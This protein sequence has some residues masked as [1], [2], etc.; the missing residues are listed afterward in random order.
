MARPAKDRVSCG[1]RQASLHVGSRSVKAG[2]LR[3][4]RFRAS[5]TSQAARRSAKARVSVGP[6]ASNSREPYLVLTPSPT[7]K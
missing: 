6:N 2:P 5:A 1:I 4:L 3:E 7:S